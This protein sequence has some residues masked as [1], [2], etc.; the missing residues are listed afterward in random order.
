MNNNY[1]ISSNTYSYLN[2][3]NESNNFTENSKNLIS[4][5]NSYQQTFTPKYISS[6]Y[7][8]LYNPN[9]FK[10][11]SF[12]PANI[13]IIRH[14]EKDPNYFVLDQNGISRAVQLPNFINNLGSK[15]YPI[16]SIITCNPDMDGSLKKPLSARPEM[17][18]ILSSFFLNI[19]M[20][21]F[22]SS[23]IS[24]PYNSDTIFQLFTNPIFTGKNV[25]IIW[26]HTNIQSLS[27]QII[28]CYNYLSNDKN[29]TSSLIKNK[30]M[31]FDNSTEEWWKK[32]TPI[33]YQ[34]QFKYN[35]KP[36]FNLPYIKYS[37][38]L[39]YW[40]TLNY[41]LVYHFS[42]NK[43]NLI[44]NILNENIYTHFKNCD[45]LIGLLQYNKGKPYDGEKFCKIPK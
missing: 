8:Y 18:G 6:N 28:Q 45:V 15:G 22:S 42:I 19:P 5:Y 43:K 16:S 10:H 1:N 33:P 31:V 12:G 4:I 25:L 2:P 11:S 44:F 35:N 30:N 39:P 29:D 26:E 13:F 32:N 34:F 9:N 20:Y 27:N 7:K 3:N 17:T 40:N 37:H 38:L 24:Q 36:E 41:N 14:G 21:I 23:N